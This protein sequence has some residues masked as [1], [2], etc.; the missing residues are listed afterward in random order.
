MPHCR[1][2]VR[3]GAHVCPHCRRRQPGAPKPVLTAVLIIVA[4]FVGG[5]IILAIIGSNM[6]D[7]PEAQLARVK[8]SCDRQYGADSLDSGRCQVAIIGTRLQENED[9][10]LRRA[11][12]DAR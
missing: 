12:E 4:V 7:S 5:F 10:K 9:R 2:D 6:D 11:V 1:E 3:A 8:E